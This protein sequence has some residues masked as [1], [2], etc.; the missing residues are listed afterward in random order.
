MTKVKHF[1]KARLDD[2][3][4]KEVISSLD[5]ELHSFDGT[6][7]G[8]DNKTKIGF[9]KVVMLKS[10]KPTS[11]EIT[12]PNFQHLSSSVEI[13]TPNNESNFTSLRGSLDNIKAI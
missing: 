12:N 9:V 13:N 5:N 4:A 1:L 2:N 11:V 10:E 3:L 7:K 6:N 8:I